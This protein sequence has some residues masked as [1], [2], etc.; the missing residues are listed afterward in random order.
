MLPNS[1]TP[2]AAVLLSQ[3]WLSLAFSGALSPRV[4][5]VLQQQDATALEVATLVGWLGR[6]WR[7]C[8]RMCKGA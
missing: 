4:L 5:Q 8:T 1:T 3:A 6:G 7:A 2:T